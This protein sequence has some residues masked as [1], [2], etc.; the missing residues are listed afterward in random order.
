[1]KK[2]TAAL[3][4]SLTVFSGAAA[5]AD[6]PSYSG[7]YPC[8]YEGRCPDGWHDTHRRCWDADRDC[9]Y[10][11]EAYDENGSG[12]GDFL[13]LRFRPFGLFLPSFP[14]FRTFPSFPIFFIL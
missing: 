9:A 8:R 1:M 2:L 4:V 11:S 14:V 3:L 13:L 5:F 7:P 10:D 12:R 6:A